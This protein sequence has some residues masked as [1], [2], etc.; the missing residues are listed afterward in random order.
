MQGLNFPVA[1]AVSTLTMEE[2]A[3][4]S[5]IQLFLVTAR[6]SQPQYTLSADDAP[7]VM[8]ICQLV[9]GMPLAIELAAAWIGVLAPAEIAAELVHNLDFLA[10]EVHDLPLRQRSMRAIFDTSW[11]LL[12]SLEQ[13]VYQ[14]L[15][16][17]RSGFTRQAAEQIAEASLLTLTA[18]VNKSLIG[19][20]HH[21]SRYGMHELLRQYAAD[22]LVQTADGENFVRNQHSAYYCAL[23]KAQ[24]D[25]LEL[26]QQP[27]IRM[28]IANDYENIAAAWDWA[29]ANGQAE[30]LFET[31]DSLSSFFVRLARV[32][33]GVIQLEKTV[34]KLEE[35]CTYSPTDSHLQYVYIKVLAHYGNFVDIVGRSEEARKLLQKSLECLSLPGLTEEDTRSLRA[36]FLVGWGIHFMVMK[37]SNTTY[38]PWNYPILSELSGMWQKCCYRRAAQ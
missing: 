16:I 12:N 3:A 26:V 36:R 6:R 17:F 5:S 14:K 31:I 32:Q 10:R 11:R 9:Q 24:S 38:R 4:Y 37:R 33:E 15:S 23:L 1:T 35:L 25:A 2:I 22:K 8:A 30:R 34:R 28:S 19:Y 27:A 18:L 13:S 29:T 7:A 20:D 21:T